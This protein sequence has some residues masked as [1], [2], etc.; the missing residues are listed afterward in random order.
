MSEATAS[1]FCR[2]FG[3]YQLQA[4]R[5]PVQVTSHGRVTGYFVSEAEFAHYQDLLR[6]EREILLVGRLPADAVAAIEVSQ[7]PEGHDD[8]DALV[9]DETGR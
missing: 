2:N 9:D 8:L 6:K 5:E 4:Q 7:Y 1:H 3:R